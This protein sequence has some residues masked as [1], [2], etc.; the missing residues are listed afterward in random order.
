MLPFEADYPLWLRAWAVILISP[1]PYLILLGDHELP[2]HLILSGYT[3]AL[4]AIE[5]Y[6]VRRSVAPASVE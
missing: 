4:F 2:G 3:L 6:R 1:I 5:T